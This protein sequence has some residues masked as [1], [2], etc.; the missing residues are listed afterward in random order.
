MY[1]VDINKP[2]QIEPWLLPVHERTQLV[3]QAQKKGK[4]IAIIIYTAPDTSTF[5]Y[6]GYNML[7]ATKKSEAWQTVFYHQN[8]LDTVNV[9]LDS[10]QLLIFSRTKWSFEY[11]EM[12]HKAKAKKIPVLYDADDLI[13]NADYLP[14]LTNT[15]NVPIVANEFQANELHYN[16]WFADIA[17]NQA[18]ARLADGY[19]ATNPFLQ[20][21]FEEAFQKPCGI[22]ENF[23][24][25][26]Q[27]AYSARC[28]QRKEKRLS[29]K[30]F[31]I[32]YFSGTPSHIN[33]FQN[34]ALELA[35]FLEDHDD[36]RLQVVGFMEFSQELQPLI[37]EGRILFTPL[38]DFL[39]L[40]RL[41]A[42]V[43]V[44]IVPLLDNEFTNCKS[45]LKFF[46]ASIV[47]TLTI[48]SPT[49]TYAHSIQHGKTGYLCQAGEWYATLESIYKSPQ[50][51]KPIVQSAHQY[52]MQR[53]SGKNVVTM[54]EDCY[55]QFV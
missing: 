9:L 48:A 54:I 16:F 1:K 29:S 52:C 6:R 19:I 27:I 50:S 51:M 31:T 32:G 3:Y 8:E 17:R 47:D 44:S 13:F 36:V 24:N 28:C 11:E 55:N 40:Q 7:Q 38:V 18:M 39:S 49:Y 41:T 34:V 20:A 37:N 5:R 21:K 45:E 12:I 42:Q 26:E 23:L 43:D 25:Q 14:L 4:Q 22:I 46:E 33:D 15:L 2:L 53:Y 10:I 30:P 35:D